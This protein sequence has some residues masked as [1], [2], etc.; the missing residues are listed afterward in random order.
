MKKLLLLLL[1]TS[2]FAYAQFTI[3]GTMNP[4]YKSNW[5]LLYKIEG[6]RQ[7]FVKNTKSKTD[8]I[9]VNGQKKAIA[10]FKIQLPATAKPGSYRITY[11]TKS[12]GFVDFL[13]NKENVSFTFNPS[14]PEQSI[15]YSSSKE[16]ILY[17]EYSHAIYIAQKKLDSI[18]V[19]VFQQPSTTASNN[20]KNALKKLS[21]VQDIYLEK[22]KGMM[23]NHYIKATFRKNSPEIILSAKKYLSFIKKNFFAN[24]DFSNKKLYN[25]SF[26]VDRITDYIFY[27]NSS[28]HTG[29]QQKLYIESISNVM[30]NITDPTFKKDV[31]EFLVTQF[32]AQKNVDIVDLLFNNYYKRLPVGLKNEVFKTEKLAQLAAE[33]GRT[34]PDFS[35][36][37]NGKKYQLSTLKDANSYV[38]V[39]W[40][41]G[42]SHCLRE[43][44]ELYTF[45]KDRKQT[46]VIAFSLEKTDYNW[47]NYIKK[48]SGW[49]NVMGLN[50][51]KNKTARTYQ[52]FSTPTYFILD[53]NKKIIAKPDTIQD[54][55][56]YFGE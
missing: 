29:E 15:N 34:A 13:F 28:D 14:F 31:I 38:L 33:I 35:W 3:N 53:K 10:T 2:T 24:I 49:H 52:I 16:N 23:A 43:I 1:L 40:S 36:Q 39:F 12:G 48:L 42:C 18:Q 45:M 11:D 19:S 44:P 54:V 47:K 30:Y 5:I 17:K 51:W 32:A 20:Y 7:I 55:I 41:A 8:T 46:S 26:L 21:N 25:S 56:A 9:L 27:L 37:E 4:P 6:A 50:K 22:S